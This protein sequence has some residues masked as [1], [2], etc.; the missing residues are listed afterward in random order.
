MDKF[1]RDIIESAPSLSSLFIALLPI[2]GALLGSWATYKLTKKLRFDN[3]QR[4]TAKK[5]NYLLIKARKALQALE[6]D[7]KVNNE[8]TRKYI[9]ETK[10]ARDNFIDFYDKESIMLPQN[11][12]DKVDKFVND[13]IA[14]QSMLMLNNYTG[15]TKKDEALKSLG[16]SITNLQDVEKILRQEFKKLAGGK[17]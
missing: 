17:K 7:F 2:L 3:E 11:I 10:T 13:F 4:E 15:V 14:A 5:F 8:L 6:V 16:E 12:V 1:C 9:D